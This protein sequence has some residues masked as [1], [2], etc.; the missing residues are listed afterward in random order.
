MVLEGKLCAEAD[1]AKTTV[2][3]NA[4][5]RKRSC[6]TTTTSLELTARPAV[7][8]CSIAVRGLARQRLKPVE[9][10]R[11]ADHDRLRQ[12]VVAERSQ[13][14]IDQRRV[15]ERPIRHGCLGTML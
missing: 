5:A 3:S 10:G 13:E 15:G 11:I 1:D 14:I 8:P 6:V 9:P 4:V 2:A 7:L 12:R